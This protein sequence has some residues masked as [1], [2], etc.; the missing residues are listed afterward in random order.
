M[1][2]SYEVNVHVI[3]HLSIQNYLKTDKIQFD[4]DVT[5]S[6]AHG[7][8]HKCIMGGVSYEAC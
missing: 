3:T 1:G 7:T 4:D 6:P 5:T 2:S 8:A